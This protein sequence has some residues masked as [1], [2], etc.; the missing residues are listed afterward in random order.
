MPHEALDSDASDLRP[1]LAARSALRLPSAQEASASMSQWSEA[2]SRAPL[3]DQEAQALLDG[4]AGM[5]FWF[6]ARHFPIQAQAAARELSAASAVE[7]A[8]SKY[9]SFANAMD[10]L[11]G[12]LILGSLARCAET[13]PAKIDVSLHG[14]FSVRALMDPSLSRM[15]AQDAETCA[16]ALH[17]ILWT[18]GWTDDGAAIPA[19]AVGFF[20]GQEAIHTIET[21]LPQWTIADHQTFAAAPFPWPLISDCINRALLSAGLD[22]DLAHPARAPSARL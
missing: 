4:S 2:A 15:P 7:R 16:M 6:W 21:H 18:F 5:L 14:E 10:V 13:F 17:D 22:A 9:K 11:S 8:A 3:A 20:G 19:S 1:L 12:V